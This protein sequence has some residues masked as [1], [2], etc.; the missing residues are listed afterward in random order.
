MT[1]RIFLH[2]LESSN[3]GTKAVYFKER[4]PDMATPNLKGTLQERMETLN[5]L[6]ADKTDI[7]IV[8]SS[9][10]GLMGT[11]FAMQ[12]EHLVD[13]LI[14]LAPAINFLD[15]SGY[16]EKPLTVPVWVYHGTDD[17]VIPLKDIQPVATR[18]FTHLTF[19]TV[20]DD[21]FLHKTFKAIDWDKLLFE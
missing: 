12:N 15:Q 11:I 17:R 21:H 1:F 18:S 10:G 9:F 2:G 3:Q 6:I 4:Y 8:G 5:Q 16:Q 20:D 13:R 7:R 19:N 14:L